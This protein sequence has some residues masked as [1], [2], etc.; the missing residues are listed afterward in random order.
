MHSI[1][2]YRKNISVDRG[3]KDEAVF[4]FFFCLQQKI[5]IIFLLLKYIFFY[6][7]KMFD[8]YGVS[9]N[10]MK[11]NCYTFSNLHYKIQ[12]EKKLTFFQDVYKTELFYKKSFKLQYFL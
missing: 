6:L 8:L 11:R 2:I 7:V 3:Y 5:G 10:V 4:F 1:L 9:L 12:L